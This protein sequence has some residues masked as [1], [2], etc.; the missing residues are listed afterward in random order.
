LSKHFDFCQKMSIKN[1][2]GPFYVLKYGQL[3]FLFL[4]DFLTLKN[5]YVTVNFSI[6][7][8]LMMSQNS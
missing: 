5:Y 1:F 6:E 4:F 7:P 2:E 3:Y 8:E